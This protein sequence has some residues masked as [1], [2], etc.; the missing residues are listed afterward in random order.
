MTKSSVDEA[1]N[2]LIGIS[3]GIAAYKIPLLVRILKKQGHS[4]KIILTQAAKGLVGIDALKTLSQ[5]PVYGDNI[6]DENFD[7]GHIRLNEWADL[8][9]LAPA[10]A[11][12]IA[13]MAHGIADNLLS[14]V[15]LSLK[16]PIVAAPAMNTA[17]WENAATQANVKTLKERGVFVLPTATG[18]LACGTVGAGRMAEPQDIAQYI[19]LALEK[20]ALQN[21]LSQKKVLIASGSTAEPIDA[22]RFITNSS[23]GKM[24]A[25]LA[26]AAIFSGAQVSVVSGPAKESLPEGIETVLVNTASQMR[27]AI[28][29]KLPESD[30]VIMAAA[31]GDFRAQTIAEKKISREDKDSFSINLVKNPDIAKEVGEKKSPNQK[32]IVFSLETNNDTER[33]VEKMKRKNAD[34]CVFNSVENAPGK[35]RSKISII[36]ENGKIKEF[37]EQEKIVSALRILEAVL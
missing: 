29:K 1:K 31:V 32:L 5:N 10:T 20:S 17:M 35:D 23:S 37:E 15:F 9:V 6:S 24:G 30:I 18:E 16:C 25:A 28:M 27:D 34:F 11:N 3:G 4:V 26:R 33:A 21:K 13:K 8:F 7:M 22:V 12:S 14:T 2:I 19:A 36:D